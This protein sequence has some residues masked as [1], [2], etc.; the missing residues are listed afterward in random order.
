MRMLV[1]LFRAVNDLGV[2]RGSGCIVEVAETEGHLVDLRAQRLC[3][4]RVHCFG[5]FVLPQ[6]ADEL[7]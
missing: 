7:D 3:R 1:L 2:Q 5:E 6:T 4:A